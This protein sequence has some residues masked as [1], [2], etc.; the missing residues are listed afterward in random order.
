MAAPSTYTE[1]TLAAFMVVEL[2][3][4]ARVLGWS[5]LSH[6]QEPINET[7]LA[8]GASDIADAT[9]VTQLRALARVMAWRAACSAL[10]TRYDF[11]D[12]DGRYSRSQM[13]KAA[14]ERVAA[15]ESAAAGWLPSVM[16][17]SPV[18]YQYDPYMPLNDSQIERLF[19]GAA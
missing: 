5:D 3:D 8:Y 15:A 6:L 11:A 17:V 2:D 14:Q 16:L 7:L 19:G 12:P 10:V 1:E 18:T 13:F 9:D 4:V